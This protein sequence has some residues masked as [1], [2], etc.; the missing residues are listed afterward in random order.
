MGNIAIIPARSGSKGLPDKNI[1]ELC[2]KPLMA[3]SIEAAIKSKCFDE[4]F[5]STDSK[6]Y[7][8]I[9]EEYGANASFLRSRETSSDT[10][11]SWDVVREVLAEFGKRGKVFDKIMLL[12]PTS[13]LRT[14]EDII[15]AFNLMEEKYA[16]AILGVTETDHSPIWCNTLPED[17]CMDNF[18]NE[19]YAGLPR[20]LLPKFYRINGAM[21]LIKSKELNVDKMFRNRCFAYVMPQ[22]RS[23]DI[24][25]P[26]DFK[27]AELLL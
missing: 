7:A 25:S 15:E 8:Q 10:A 6:K 2:G 11:G 1:K 21:Y 24:D 3:Y 14:A 4:V 16:N 23:V 17:G 27:L 26:I 22:E 20:Q 5:V 19:K 12:Q 18:V 9:A 13:P